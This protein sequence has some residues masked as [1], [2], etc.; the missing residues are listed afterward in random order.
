MRALICNEFAALGDVQAGDLPVPEI[1]PDQVLI[2]VAAAGVNFYDT[3]IVQGKYQIKPPLPFSPGGESAGTV[4]TVGAGV[5]H[6]KPGDR[7]VAFSHY[8]A[9]AE[10][11]RAP[12]SQVFPLPDGVSFDI[13]AAS[14][15]AYGTAWMALYDRGRM[16]PG[17]T[18]LVL[19]A[20]GGVGLAAVQIAHRAGAR[21]I[22]AASSED[23]LA[24]CASAGADVCVNY[25]TDNL[26]DA[27][28]SAVGPR[29]ADIVIDVV[30]N[31]YTEAALRATGWRGRVMIIGFAAGDIPR[32]PANLVLLKGNEVSGVLWDGLLEKDPEMAREQVADL[33]AAI[34]DGSL[35]PRITARFPLEQGLDALNT[36]AERRV[37]GKVIVT[38]N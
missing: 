38:P 11:C 2:R 3:L 4:E 16:Q 21:V 10:F 36:L 29:G 5:T 15:V 13:A 26:K 24:L 9:F 20:A 28:K 23:K 1:G 7:V 30:G 32:I 27:F 34:A 19:G 25:A 35:A 6:V 22:A 8:G 33:M 14:L 31:P 17:E 18:V 37:T 12:A